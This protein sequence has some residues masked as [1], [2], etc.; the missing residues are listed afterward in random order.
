MKRKRKD[1]W[2]RTEMVGMRRGCH[3]PL[4]QK[5]RK[6]ES[7]PLLFMFTFNPNPILN[8]EM[9]GREREM[10]CGWHWEVVCFVVYCRWFMSYCL[11][12]VRFLFFLLSFCHFE[13][14]RWFF[15]GIVWDLV[16]IHSVLDSV[17]MVTLYFL[18]QMVVLLLSWCIVLLCSSFVVYWEWG[19]YSQVVHSDPVGSLE[20]LSICCSV[21]ECIWYGT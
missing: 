15:I 9:R 17:V 14:I 16:V 2:N 7:Q 8:N 1:D 19:L 6:S 5:Q 21:I 4:H 11:L 20:S 12:G 10:G 13:W 18:Y 3:W